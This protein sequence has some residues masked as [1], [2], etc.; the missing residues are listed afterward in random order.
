MPVTLVS[1]QDGATV[2]EDMLLVSLPKGV[3]GL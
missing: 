3:T 1:Q 2:C